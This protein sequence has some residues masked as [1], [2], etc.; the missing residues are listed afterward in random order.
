MLR[1]LIKQGVFSLFFFLAPHYLINELTKKIDNNNG[2]KQ[3]F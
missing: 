3:I 2:Y 1:I